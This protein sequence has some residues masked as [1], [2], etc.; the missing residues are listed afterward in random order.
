MIELTQKI[1]T[2]DSESERAL[3]KADA[4]ALNV[5][6]EADL[7]ASRLIEEE[8]QLFEK[9]KER[10]AAAADEKLEVQRRQAIAALEQKMEAYDRSLDVEALIEHL[11]SAAKDRVCH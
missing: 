2:L 10:D 3:K 6:K 9:Q 1:L 4:R 7:H 11:L 8:Q 5:M